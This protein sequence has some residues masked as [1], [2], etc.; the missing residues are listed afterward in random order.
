MINRIDFLISLNIKE[1]GSMKITVWF[2]PRPKFKYAYMNPER[3]LN[4]DDIFTDF[5]RIEPTHLVLCMTFSPL[6]F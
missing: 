4:A 3:E 5:I 1:P 6:W 2:G